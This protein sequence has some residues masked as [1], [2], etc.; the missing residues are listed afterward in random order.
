MDG[1]RNAINYCGFKDL[2]Y[3]GLDYTWCNMQE[4]DKRIYLRLDR[5]LATGK[6]IEKF[7]E[8]RVHHLVDSTSDHYTLFFSN[9]LPSKQPQS[10][11]FH[12]EAMLTKKED[13][14]EIIES[15]W[16]PRGDLNTSSGLATSL[17][18]CASKFTTWNSSTFG[19]IPKQIQEKR[20]V[21][22]VMA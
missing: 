11:R 6:W 17:K 10:R 15:F 19:Q 8:I 16:G 4:E 12:F 14:I 13:C 20:K 1:F 2:G 22:N 18:I 21:L 9:P 7:R 3:S 5:A